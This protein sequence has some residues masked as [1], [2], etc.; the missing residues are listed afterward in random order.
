MILSSHMIAFLGKSQPLMKTGKKKK[1]YLYGIT[2][3][4]RDYFNQP[5]YWLIQLRVRVGIVLLI[6]ITEYN[7]YIFYYLLY[8]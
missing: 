8:K 1:L 3:Q 6:L 7:I 5:V 2:A 4:F